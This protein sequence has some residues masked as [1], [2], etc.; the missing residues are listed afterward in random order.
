MQKQTNITKSRYT[1]FRHCAKALW[2]KQYMPE[3]AKEDASR[4]ARMA[5]G[6]QIGELARGLFGD[7]SDMTIRHDDGRL[8]ITAMVSQTQ[9]CL[10]DGT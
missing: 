5:T 10:N 6:T 1:L 4:D 8:D 2:L 3:V 9:S 7:Y